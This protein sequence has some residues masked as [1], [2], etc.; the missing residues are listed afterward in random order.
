MAIIRFDRPVFRSPMSEFERMRRDMNAL[1]RVVG[2]YEDFP[3]LPAGGVYPALNISEDTDNVYVRAE[4]PGIAAT[5]LQL[6]VEG[7]TMVIKGERKACAADEKLSFHRREIECGSFSRAI[8]LPTRV[9]TDKVQ[10]KSVDGILT[11]TLPKAEEVKPK[12][13]TVNVG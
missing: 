2:G 12:K 11:I 3:A 13:I 4:A 5:D 7:E 6:S 9:R 10:A 8:T 1:M